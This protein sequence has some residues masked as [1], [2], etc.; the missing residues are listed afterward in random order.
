M[1]LWDSEDV[2]CVEAR[3]IGLD[4]VTIRVDEL[5]QAA[6]VRLP[7]RREVEH[8]GRF[9]LLVRG[10]VV[11]RSE[12]VT[13]SIAGCLSVRPVDCRAAGELACEANERR[14]VQEF[15]ELSQER[16]RYVAARRRNAAVLVQ[17]LEAVGGGAVR[18]FTQVLVQLFAV[19]P[20]QLR[21]R[22]AHTLAVV[23]DETPG[24]LLRKMSMQSFGAGRRQNA[25]NVQ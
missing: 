21:L 17:E 25:R 5:Q 7:R 15:Q 19:L 2:Q 13:R 8:V 18:L 24:Q 3:R 11:V 12:E 6:P 16:G 14:R 1:Q 23:D 20:P 10:G 22:L 9:A 4:D